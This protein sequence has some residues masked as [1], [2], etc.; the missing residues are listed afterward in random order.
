[1]V[2]GLKKIFYKKKDEVT[3]KVFLLTASNKIGYYIDDF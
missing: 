3:I 1:M 2:L